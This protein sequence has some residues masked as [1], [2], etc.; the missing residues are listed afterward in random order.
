MDT[1]ALPISRRS[2][3]IGLTVA[4]AGCGDG[5]MS[6]ISG[7]LGGGSQGPQLATA[8]AETWNTAT[9][10]RF[11]AGAVE[12]QLTSVETVP[13]VGTRPAQLRKQAFIAAFDVVGGSY[14]PGDRAYTIRH[15]SIPTFDIFLTNSAT[16]PSRLY[17]YFN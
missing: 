17:A 1:P 14:L 7:L 6:T 3:V 2:M 5:G 9:G 13:T 16:I 11:S 10:T 4:V 15:A 8:E 12:M